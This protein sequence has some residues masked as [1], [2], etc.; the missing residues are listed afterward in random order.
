MA[1]QLQRLGY[2]VNLVGHLDIRVQWFGTAVL[3]TE[4]Q[5][6]EVD[7]GTFLP[8]LVNLKKAA[9]KLRIIKKK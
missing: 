2:T 1:R 4:I 8:S 9:D 6:E 5:R 3:D 7:P